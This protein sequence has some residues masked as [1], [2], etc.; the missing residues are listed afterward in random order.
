VV[1]LLFGLPLEFC[2]ALSL[3]KRARDVAIGLPALA[4]WQV[5]EGR[6]LMIAKPKALTPEPAAEPD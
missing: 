5:L 3:I 2:M 1:G 6:R 4:L